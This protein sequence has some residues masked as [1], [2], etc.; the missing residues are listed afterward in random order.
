MH[1]RQCVR[2]GRR[3]IVG[4]RVSAAALGQAGPDVLVVGETRRTRTTGMT[5]QL[6]E[7]PAVKLRVCGGAG[8]G[9]DDGDDG[10]GRMSPAR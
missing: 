8:D 2:D 7:K 1:G 4:V 9:D 3:A 10:G 5:S 6:T